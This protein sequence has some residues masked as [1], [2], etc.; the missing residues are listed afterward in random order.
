MIFM[1]VWLLGLGWTWYNLLVRTAFEVRLWPDSGRLQFRSVFRRTET[2]IDAV[3]KIA[4]T[5][6][7]GMRVVFHHRDGKVLVLG[8]FDGMSDLVF[9]IRQANPGVTTRG[10]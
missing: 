10:V 3:S 8:P 4:S 5:S 9:R 7:N 1:A 2:T 6:I